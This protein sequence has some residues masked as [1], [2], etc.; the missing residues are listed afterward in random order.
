[1]TDSIRRAKNGQVLALA[2][3]VLITGNFFRATPSHALTV[4]RAWAKTEELSAPGIIQFGVPRMDADSTGRPLLIASARLGTTVGIDW[5]FSH[6]RDSAWAEPILGQV[7]AGL[8]PEP[9]VS[10]PRQADIVWITT[11]PLSGY[12]RLLLSRFGGGSLAVPETTLADLSAAREYSAA[13]S[14]ARRWTASAEQPVNQKQV[15]VRVAYSDTPHVWHEVEPRGWYEW[16]GC[17]IVPLSDSTAMLAHAGDFGLRVAVLRG[18][19][20]TDSAV[21]DPRGNGR[22][23][24]PR[25]R[26]RPS[27]GVWLV[28]SDVLGLQIA[29]NHTGTWVWKDSVKAVHPPGET[30]LSGWLDASRDTEERPILAW[31]DFGYGYTGR[32]IGCAAFPNDSGWDAGEEIPGSGNQFTS[33][34]VARDVNGDGWF[35]WDLLRQPGVFYTHTYVKATVGIPAVRGRPTGRTVNWTISE[36]APKSWWAVL[37]AEGN[38]PLVPLARVQ[39]GSGTSMTYVDATGAPSSRLR[40]AIR[41]E[42]VDKRYEWT[43]GAATWWAEGRALTVR[44]SAG[45]PVTNGVVRYSIAGAVQGGL[46]VRIYDLAGREVWRMNPTASGTG[47]DSLMLRTADAPTPLRPGLY[48]MRVT[49]DSG[50]S[51]PAAKLVI[52]R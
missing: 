47:E 11:D 46:D 48:L 27:G 42:S 36:P 39:A 49:D 30:F 12:G 5:S 14:N 19:Q 17:N 34:K 13:I 50:V 2:V 1:M 7:K 16:T 15:H 4:G 8:I 25:L 3:V 9:V 24:H 44:F 23:I 6:W 40:Y 37:R 52:L 10:I 18:D 45:N 20:W 38:G 21:V 31:G 26:L 51:A 33:P 32:S 29:S 28:W 41:R 35:A 22:A 43:G